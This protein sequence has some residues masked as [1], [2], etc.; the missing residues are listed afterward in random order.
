MG[1]IEGRLSPFWILR[2]RASTEG[3]VLLGS[4]LKDL[5]VFRHAAM[6]V[7][8]ERIGILRAAASA[9]VFSSKKPAGSTHAFFSQVPSKKPMFKPAKRW[10]ISGSIWKGIIWISFFRVTLAFST[11]TCRNFR[12]AEKRTKDPDRQMDDCLVQ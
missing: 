5:K 11:G 6:C 7:C 3:L 4:A 12:L 1:L 9:F 2:T 10:A 8:S